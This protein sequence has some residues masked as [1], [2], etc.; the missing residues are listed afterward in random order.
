MSSATTP[1]GNSDHRNQA[2]AAL[3]LSLTVFAVVLLGYVFTT[4]R[5]DETIRTVLAVLLFGGLVAGVTK[6]FSY[7][8]WPLVA[9]T[10]LVALLQRPTDVPNH[11]WMMMYV[12]FAISLSCLIG[13]TDQERLDDLAASTRWL[14]VVLMGFA[15]VQK[16][17]SPSFMDATYIGFELARGSFATPVLKF[18]SETYQIVESNN[19]LVDQLHASPPSELAEVTLPPPYPGLTYLAYGFTAAIIGMEAWLFACMVWLPKRVMTHLSLIAFAGTLAVL[20]QEFTF[21]SVVCTLGLLSCGG[22]HK[23]VRLIYVVL[24][25][26]TAAAVLKTLNVG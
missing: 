16:L 5:V 18:F 26:L 7:W 6:R 12:S 19:A 15:T 20:R 25:I 14:I 11:H 8:V 23:W 22:N 2:T 13:R 3:R 4:E 21:I 10:L 24:A 9:I 17:L 1:P